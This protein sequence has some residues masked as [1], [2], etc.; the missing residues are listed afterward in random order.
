MRE[1]Y[2]RVLVSILGVEGKTK[3]VSLVGRGAEV[4]CTLLVSEEGSQEGRPGPGLIFSQDIKLSSAQ[5]D[6]RR[7]SVRGAE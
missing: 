2:I 4:S 6:I 5:P 7:K 3:G 1:T